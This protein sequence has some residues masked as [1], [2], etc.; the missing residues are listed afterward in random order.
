M[1]IAIVDAG[2]NLVPFSCM[3][4]AWLGTFKEAIKELE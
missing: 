1:N 3:D 4:G 2:A